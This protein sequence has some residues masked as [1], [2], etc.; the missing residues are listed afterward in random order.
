MKIVISVLGRD[1]VGII[2]MVATVLAENGV[3]ILNLDQTILDGFFNMIMTAD[4]SGASIS[5][6]ELQQIMKEKG[7]A[8]GLEI[9]VQH[10]DIFQVMHRV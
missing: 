8:I 4:M 1:R 6:K 3:N 2:A 9:R 5:L 10:A 7:E